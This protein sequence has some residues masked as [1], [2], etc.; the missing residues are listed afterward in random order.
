MLAP[1]KKSYNQPRQHIKKQRHYFANNGLSSQS[2]GFSS[3]HVWMWELD[4]RESCAPKNWCFC[5]VVLEKA[6]KSPLDCKEIQPVHPKGNQSILEEFW[7]FS[8]EYSLEGLMLKLNFQ[9]SGHLMQRPDSFEKTLMLGKI[10]GRKRRGR[11]RMRWLDGIMD[12]MDMSGRWCWTGRPGMLLSMGSQRVR[13]NWATKLNWTELTSGGQSIGASASASVLPMNT[14]DWI[15]R[16]PLGLTGWIFLQPKVLS[17][18]FSNTT[19]QK[20]HFLSAQLS[21]WS[22]SHIHTWLLEKP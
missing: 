16:F 14:Q 22:S 10:E 8:P 9:Y 19:V 6:L 5:T 20:H 15:L 4:Y 12:S 1:W 11:Q 3:S 2:Y 21:I 13:H 7:V 18:V 17:R